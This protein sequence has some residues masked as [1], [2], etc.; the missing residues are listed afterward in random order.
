MGRKPAS[1]RKTVFVKARLTVAEKKR[2]EA[3]ARQ[4]GRSVASWIRYMITQTGV[5]K[6]RAAPG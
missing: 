4:D 2:V 5:A 6:P 1:A 3:A